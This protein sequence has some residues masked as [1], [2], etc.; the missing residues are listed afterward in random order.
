MTIMNALAEMAGEI[1]DEMAI[2]AEFV[3]MVNRPNERSQPDP[4]RPK[5]C[6]CGVYHEPFQFVG[7]SPGRAT[8]I[9]RFHET[10]APSTHPSLSIRPATLP[11]ALTQGDLVH[12]P[13]LGRVFRIASLHREMHT[14]TRLV[15]EDTQRIPA[16]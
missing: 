9:E 13:T 5:A 16:S 1:D 12:L 4:A 14:R 6:A 2:T 15:L 10:Q 7:D 8:R 11:Y 3:G